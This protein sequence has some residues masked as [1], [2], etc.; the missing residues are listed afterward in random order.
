MY[1]LCW[2]FTA[3]LR[4]SLAVMSQGYSCCSARILEHRLKS[5]A[6][7][8][9]LLQGRWDLPRPGI[10]PMFPKLTGRIFN[11]EP[12]GEPL[13]FLFVRIFVLFLLGFLFCSVRV[14]LVVV[15]VIFTGVWLLLFNL[16]I[17]IGS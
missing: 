10:E 12:P 6:T 4:L 8:A 13:C 9:E 16:F 7:R 5:D 3:V 1:W 11:T 15:V 2:V 14:V 17:L